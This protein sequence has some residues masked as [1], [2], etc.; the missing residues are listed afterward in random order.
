[1]ISFL[2]LCNQIN[3]GDKRKRMSAPIN[4]KDILSVTIEAIGK[5]GDGIAKHKGFTIF[6]PK[7]EKGQKIKVRIT[8]VLQRFAFAEKAK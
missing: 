1:M 2:L 8:R 4:G 3:R 6:V 5:K 7:T